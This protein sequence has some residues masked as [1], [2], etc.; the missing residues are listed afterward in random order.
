M[1]RIRPVSKKAL[2][3]TIFSVLAANAVAALATGTLRNRGSQTTSVLDLTAA[4]PHEQQGYYHGIPGISGGGGAWR[5]GPG[6]TVRYR[7]PLDLE[8]VNAIPNKDGDFVVEISLRNASNAA[9]DLPSTLNVTSIE[10]PENR[11]RR[12]FFFKLQP[13]GG[14]AREGDT[15][16]FAATAGSISIPGSSVAIEPNKA[17]RILLPASSEAIRRYLVSESHKLIVRLSCQEWKLDDDRFFLAGLSTD[18]PSE[19]TIAFSLHGG[20][21][22]VVRP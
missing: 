4:V 2:F 11:A 10:R 16:G 20:Q 9:F 22:A 5:P 18:L 14:T 6:D 19:N 21:V 8:I 13:I 1:R 3:S 12:I 15:V 17:L 7:L